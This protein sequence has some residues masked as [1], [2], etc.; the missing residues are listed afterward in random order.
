MSNSSGVFLTCPHCGGQH[1]EGAEFCPQCGERLAA[2]VSAC[3]VC[4]SAVFR[5]IETCPNCGS[6]L[7]AATEE[8]V[9]EVG[10]PGIVPEEPVSGESQQEPVHLADEGEALPPLEIGLEDQPSTGGAELSLQSGQDSETLQAET[11]A[12]PTAPDRPPWLSPEAPDV[13]CPGC[14]RQ[15]PGGGQYCPYCGAVLAA[16]GSREAALPLWLRRAGL[17]AVVLLVLAL[18]AWGGDWLA[19][20]V[21]RSQQDATVEIRAAVESRGTPAAAEQVVSVS[22]NTAVP[23][24]AVFIENTVTLWEGSAS[25]SSQPSPAAEIT[26]HSPTPPRLAETAPAVEAVQ[27]AITAAP[28]QQAA[29]PGEPQGK[30]VFV[31]QLFRDEQRDQICLMNADGSGW[32]RM[33]QNDAADHN[34]PTFSP[35]GDSILY[36]ARQ[37]GDFQIYEMDLDGRVSQLTYGAG[38]SYAPHV[39]ADGQRIVYTHEVGDIQ[40]VWVMNRDGSGAYQAYGPPQGNG[41]DPV[42]SPG[43][44]R[45]LFASLRGDEIQLYTIRSDGSD[46][47]Q[48]TQLDGL[49][50]RSDW[51]PGGDL[52][53]TY[54]GPSWEREI[55]LLDASGG[56]LNLITS[57][58]NNLAPNFSPYSSEWIVFTSYR[59][60]YRDDNGCEIYIM[61]T[62]GS[63]IRRLTDNTYCDW[64][65]GWGL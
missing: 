10:E 51:S 40:A 25:R 37:G 31:C 26:Q 44:E 63:D 43:G 19:S 8:H 23:T 13:I 56:S 12:G 24:T 50:G 27:A 36:T 61:R 1:P 4:G 15:I 7:G 49:R 35:Q 6:W 62:D 32:R 46:L 47:K 14:K 20:W 3:P 59:D 38:G 39:S 42:W 11:G 64:Q 65:P 48:I 21:N 22:R 5:G 34:Y 28:A 41:W 2:A 16:A 17:G 60:R 33:T 53:A 55:A 45:I 52:I 58:G 54:I 30:I 9:Q 57:G 18:A 29:E